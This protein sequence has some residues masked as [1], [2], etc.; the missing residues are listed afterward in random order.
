MKRAPT[1]LQRAY[2]SVDLSV[3]DRAIS[4][5]TQTPYYYDSQSRYVYH[6]TSAGSKGTTSA[7]YYINETPSLYSF[8]TDPPPIVS[9]SLT[10][11]TN[12]VIGESVEKILLRLLHIFAYILRALVV[13][14]QII[15]IVIL[16]SNGW[17]WYNLFNVAS[18]LAYLFAHLGIM[19]QNVS[20][21]YP[22]FILDFIVT[23]FYTVFAI[24]LWADANYYNYFQYP[25]YL[26]RMTI[27]DQQVIAFCLLL[28]VG[29]MVLFM[30]VVG[31]VWWGRPF[32]Y[33]Y[34]KDSKR[35]EKDYTGRIFFSQVFGCCRYE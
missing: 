16:F 10:T 4:A 24:L 29:F 11:T 23:I 18:L 26:Y 15:L 31:R 5:G 9:E 13:L 30:V 7:V 21:L 22:F 34:K 28:S 1:P 27:V 2:S 8:N 3:E 6:D 12:V 25:T 19:N 17:G 14:F 32:C 33:P 35:V 20:W